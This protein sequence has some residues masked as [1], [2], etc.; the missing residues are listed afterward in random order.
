MV[1]KNSSILLL[2][3]FITINIRSVFLLV[4]CDCVVVQI[5]D[6]SRVFLKYLCF[7]FPLE[8]ALCFCGWDG[9]LD[10]WILLQCLCADYSFCEFTKNTLLSHFWK[11]HHF[12]LL[13]RCR[14][15]APWDFALSCSTVS[16][17]CSG[18][19]WDS[20]GPPIPPLL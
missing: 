20:G 4:P 17:S 11:C 6:T 12:P 19:P 10:L 15:P 2:H 3:C 16:P 9:F 13:L 18:D 7:F 5:V 1:L 8:S 14:F